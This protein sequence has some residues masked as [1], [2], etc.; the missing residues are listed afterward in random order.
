MPV[1]PSRILVADDETVNLKIMDRFLREAGHEPLLACSGLEALAMLDPTVELAFLDVMMP[2]VDGFEVVRSMRADP[3]LRDI[4]VIMV[5][6][7]GEGE[8]LER[9]FAAGANDFLGK[10]FDREELLARVGAAAMQVNL[11][12]RLKQAYERISREIDLVAGLQKRLL[13]DCS[14]RLGRAAVE[15]YYRPSG[16]ASGDYYDFFSLPGGTIRAVMA[17]VSGHGARAAVLM[18]VVRTL[19]R[20]S[21]KEVF[22]EQRKQ[23]RA[24]AAKTLDELKA[25]GVTVYQLADAAKWRQATEPLYAEFSAKSPATKQMIETVDGRVRIVNR[26]ALESAAGH[27]LRRR[28]KTPYSGTRAVRESPRSP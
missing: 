5:T 28:L 18:A 10:P 19:V 7:A 6:A 14:P 26:E 9:A 2:G 8:L 11:N 4:P 24:N 13:P 12:R 23:N 17:D 15:C 20:V 16:R 27:M 21:A 22:A 1:K 25:S 3:A